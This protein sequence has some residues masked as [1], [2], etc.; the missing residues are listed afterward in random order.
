VLS[1]RLLV[2]AAVTALIVLLVQAVVLGV[3]VL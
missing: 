3:R 2:V 1:P